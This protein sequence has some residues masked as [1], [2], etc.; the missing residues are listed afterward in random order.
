MA[1]DTDV[2]Q[3][4]SGPKSG[5]LGRA[6]TLL[7]LVSSHVDGIGVREAARQTGIDR[8][9]VSRILTQFEELGYVEQ[10]RDRGLYSAG[11][12]LFAIVAALAERDTLVKA[13]E[14]FLKD[15]VAQYNET[16]YVAARVGDGLVFRSKVDCE[17]TI[18]YVIEMGKQFPLLSGASG[19]AI[20]A[21]LPEEESDSIIATGLVAHTP[22]SITDPDEFRAQLRVDR[23]L[24]Y[25][26]SPGRWVRNGA[27]IAAPFFDA[28]G[29][30]AGAITLSCPADRLESLSTEEV[31]VSI[32]DAAHGLTRRLGLLGDERP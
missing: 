27:G 22:Q 15:I 2:D 21:G 14:P 26:F 12:Q 30:C 19:M 25:S 29:R 6:I 3:R 23:Q 17:H 7:E 24:G 13:A 18:R 10:E 11:P 32:R 28:T 1:S 5:I 9:A 8:S 20:L 31:G 4:E 16:C